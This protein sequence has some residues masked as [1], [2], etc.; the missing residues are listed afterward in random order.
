MGDK[1]KPNHEQPKGE[2][3]KFMVYAK[4]RLEVGEILNHAH[5]DALLG[6][7][8]ETK[9][10]NTFIWINDKWLGMYSGFG[11]E[12]NCMNAAGKVI[13]LP[14]LADVQSACIR[15]VRKSWDDNNYEHLRM[16]L[17]NP[18]QPAV[19][20]VIDMMEKTSF[21]QELCFGHYVFGALSESSKQVRVEVQKS[22]LLGQALAIWPQWP[23]NAPWYS[24]AQLS[25]AVHSWESKNV[26]LREGVLN[27]DTAQR[28]FEFAVQDGV[29]L[30]K[31][32]KKIAHDHHLGSWCDPAADRLL[33]SIRSVWENSILGRLLH[34][35]KYA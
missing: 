5:K 4:T 28:W 25:L 15:C 9:F 2:T 31:T 3:M 8:Y 26:A 23:T 14:P 16:F 22:E 6:K 11:T 20:L 34:E 32:C 29:V 10:T 35:Y 1:S 21:W 24:S 33:P 17:P 7:G 13:P 27:P 12:Y 18:S 19:F 30:S